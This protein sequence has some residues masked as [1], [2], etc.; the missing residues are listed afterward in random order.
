M[1][2]GSS[3]VHLQ[4]GYVKGL[5]QKLDLVFTGTKQQTLDSVHFEMAH[6]ADFPAASSKIWHNRLYGGFATQDACQRQIHPLSCS[7]LSDCEKKGFRHLYTYF[8][9]LDFLLYLLFCAVQAD[10]YML[11]YPSTHTPGTSVLVWLPKISHP[12]SGCVYVCVCVL[13]PAIYWVPKR[14][15]L[16]AKWGHFRLSSQL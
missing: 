5:M 13:V 2:H 11:F 12:V 15:A 9:I 14:S 1:S 4:S 8:W 3:G 7:L 10:V 16:P 6:Y